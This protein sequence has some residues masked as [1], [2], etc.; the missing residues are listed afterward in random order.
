MPSSDGLGKGYYLG[1]VRVDIESD[2]I[3]ERIINQG[4]EDEDN[5]CKKGKVGV[6]ILFENLQKLELL[7]DHDLTLCKLADELDET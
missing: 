2:L 5:R 7:D 4:A 6:F 1:N 3:G